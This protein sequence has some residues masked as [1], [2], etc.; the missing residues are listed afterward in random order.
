MVRAGSLDREQRDSWES[1]KT[2][3][4]SGLTGRVDSLG[5]M[6]RTEGKSKKAGVRER[7]SRKAKMREQAEVQQA[8]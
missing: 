7:K 2:G 1:R 4:D 3:E 8:D 6:D 5:E